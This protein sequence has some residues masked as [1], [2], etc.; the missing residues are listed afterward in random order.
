SILHMTNLASRQVVAGK[1]GV[2]KFPEFGG[3]YSDWHEVY[4]RVQPVRK[5]AANVAV[6][7]KSECV[8]AGNKQFR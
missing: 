1:D 3:G 4:I 2:S 5:I 7:H 8:D 6:L